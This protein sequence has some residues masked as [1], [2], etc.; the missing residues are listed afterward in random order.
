VSRIPRIL[1]LAGVAIA[2]VL[3]VNAIAGADSLPRLF[4]GAR[5]WAEGTQGEPKPGDAAKSN[6]VKAP[7]AVCAPT[8]AELAK[9]AGLSPAELRIL[10]SL[11]DR[12]GQLDEREQGID[13]QLQLLA[14]A[15]AKLD[16]RYK[17]LNGL[18]GDIQ[19][20]LGQ[21]DA[22]QQQEITRLVTVFSAMKAKDA[23]A[24]MRVLDDSVRLPIAA[25][26]K[27]RTLAAILAQM[28][29]TEAKVITEQL[30]RRFTANAA[31]LAGK[32]AIKPEP[33]LAEAAPPPAEAAALAGL[34]PAAAPA[35]KLPAKRVAKP[36]P[37]PAAKQ[38]KAD[39]VPAAPVKAPADKAADPAKAG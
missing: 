31:I 23:A 12:R 14:A 10:Q 15:E 34:A 32:E 9:E 18:K 20:L 30:A 8:A 19:T 5:A 4:S 39:P 17:S 13:V 37:K 25:K 29:P 2:G 26:M 33:K 3:A 38:A 27:E 28:P 16:A 36:A 21:A 24:Q 6:P 22:E 7:A 35:A 11:G 1:P